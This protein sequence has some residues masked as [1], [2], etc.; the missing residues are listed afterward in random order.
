M[1]WRP[2]TLVV[3]YVIIYYVKAYTN[4][5]LELIRGSAVLLDRNFMGMLASGALELCL[6]SNLSITR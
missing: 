3:P 4:I 5:A 2:L 1:V 6:E